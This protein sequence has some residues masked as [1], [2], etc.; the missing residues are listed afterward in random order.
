MRKKTVRSLIKPA[1]IY[2]LVS[3][4]FLL[5]QNLYG[6]SYNLRCKN[7]GI[8]EG[9]SNSHI[10]DIIQD[11]Y[12]Y[13]WIATERGLN[14]YDGTEIINYPATKERGSY[15]SHHGI[16]DLENNID[17]GLWI[18]TLNGLIQYANGSFQQKIITEDTDI[19]INGVGT[20]GRENWFYTSEGIYKQLQ[21]KTGFEKVEL[22]PR[23]NFKYSFINS[24]D[25]STVMIIPQS[26]ELWICTVAKGVYI[27]NLETGEIKSFSF[28]IEAN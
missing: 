21:D 24:A 22:S 17:G 8:P 2:Y 19:V 28:K 16:I 1:I 27:K 11:E 12:H 20:I 26:K 9:L 13:I 7:I 5:V 10:T 3:L 14:R 18:V 4:A 23:T 15:L 25:I 6:Q